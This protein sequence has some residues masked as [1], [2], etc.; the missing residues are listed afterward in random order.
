MSFTIFTDSCS[1][2]PGRLL[3]ELEI[4]VLPC[5]YM[6]DGQT[7]HYSGDIEHFDAPS[8]YDL[9]RAGKT[10]TTS[11]LNTQTFLDHFRPVLEEGSDIVY[12]GIS[13]GISGTFQ[14][15]S[16]AIAEL[17]EQFPDRN[18][19][20]VDSRGAGFGTGILTCLCADFRAQ[21]LD[22]NA[23]ADRLNQATD[24][25]CEYFTVDDLRYLHNTGRISAATATIGT[26]LN[27]KPLLYGND[28]GHIVSCG[29]FRGRKKAIDAIVEK[30]AAKAAD[31]ANNR[32][33]ISHGDCLEEAQALAERIRAIAEP[34]EL[35]ICPH[36][37][38][39]GAH[40]GPGMLA[41]FFFG[42]CR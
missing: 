28:E 9:I 36:E 2:L 22:A 10:V 5:S 19:R 23:A 34:K 18:I 17:A 6:V 11:L 26:M 24:H 39:T 30:Y 12:V 42:D 41:L 15:A 21:G 35:I 13:S 20:A 14:A 33:A 38:F 27:I 3:R 25:L 40:V 1:N 37:P 16:I 7:V 4:Q 8:Y 31:P 32:V 29:K